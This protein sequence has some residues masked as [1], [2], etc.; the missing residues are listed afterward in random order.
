MKR[1]E[2]ISELRSIQMAILDNVDRYCR[3]N[4]IGYFLSSGT[5]IGAIRHGGYIPW[6]DDIDIYIPRAD[7]ERFIRQYSDPSGRYR[8][9]KP[10]QKEKY[11]YTFAK[12][13]DTATVM[14]EDE[15][16]GFEIGVYV[17]VFPVDYVPEKMWQRRMVFKLKYLLYKIRRCK[18]QPTNWLDS[19]FAYLCYRWLPVPVGVINRLIRFLVVRSKPTSSVCDMSEAGHAITACFP[20]RLM[21]SFIDIKFEGRTYQTIAGY[22]EY[23]TLTYGD[24]MQLPPEGQR[25]HHYFKAWWKDGPGMQ[26]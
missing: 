7:Y 24:Y 25:Y 16:D 5:L 13:V 20:A 21:D 14:V 10:G 22:H 11:L 4:G 23:L 6:D 9:A 12:V 26:D 17:D 15:V 3:D 1:I 18:M 2:D 19:R 8:L